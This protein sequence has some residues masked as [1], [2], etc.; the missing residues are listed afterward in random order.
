VANGEELLQGGKVSN[1]LGAL[2]C[3]GADI[4]TFMWR[5]S[6]RCNVLLRGTAKAVLP[7]FVVTRIRQARQR[8]S[9]NKERAEARG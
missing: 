5:L 8:Q 2:C 4:Y 3:L 9:L 6:V 7:E 1:A